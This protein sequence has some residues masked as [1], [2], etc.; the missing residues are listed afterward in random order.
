M[1]RTQARPTSAE[2]ATCAEIAAAEL[3]QLIQESNKIIDSLVLDFKASISAD[4]MNPSGIVYKRVTFDEKA[5]DVEVSRATYHEILRSQ[6]SVSTQSIEALIGGL[7]YLDSIMIKDADFDFDAKNKQNISLDDFVDIVQRLPRV[8]GLRVQWAE[9]LGLAGAFA[10]I[11]PHGSLLDGLKGIREMT[12][13]D[14]DNVCDRFQ[15]M[16]RSIVTEEWKKINFVGGSL[17]GCTNLPN[18]FPDCFLEQGPPAEEASRERLDA[19]IGLPSP[20]VLRAM[21][22]EHQSD[23]WFACRA[24]G[25]AT[26]PRLEFARLLETSEESDPSLELLR[27]A[28]VD[29]NFAVG[30]E[31]GSKILNDSGQ[32]GGA[33]DALQALRL[34]R[35]A[36]ESC[37][38]GRF[39]GEHC[40]EQQ[41]IRAAVTLAAATPSDARILR[42]SCYALAAGT[43]ERLFPCTPTLGGGQFAGEV[44]ARGVDVAIQREDS[45]LAADSTGCVVALVF[46]L[47]CGDA[48][49]TRRG[50]DTSLVQ[51][52]Q[53][54]AVEIPGLA[55]APEVAVRRSACGT[56]IYAETPGEEG[57]RRFLHSLG[58]EELR[59]RAAAIV[60]TAAVLAL[61]P[62]PP[63]AEEDCISTLLAAG[64][65]VVRP[66]RR[67]LS[68]AQLAMLDGVQAARLRLDEA[69]AAHLGTGP[70][71]QVRRG[72]ARRV[73][74][75]PLLD[76]YTQIQQRKNAGSISYVAAPSTWPEALLHNYGH[77][78]LHAET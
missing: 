48:D 77:L 60:S 11:L 62:S 33:E 70:L 65:W 45:G 54:T 24:S 57:L 74:S 13:C 35:A 31:R 32:N 52:V 55:G 30:A 27:A 26:T 16:L 71:L 2:M 58:G 37:R 61:S 69:I 40:D 22:C 8:S 23:K 78:Y 3:K 75:C 10:S 20:N 39:P 51:A 6:G 76:C 19:L 73:R 28:C 50:G 1:T 66:A 46:S 49:Y 17:S 25:L 5:D 53:E 47:P 29:S 56:V 18:Q 44:S 15:P 59:R 36:V 7:T 34:A 38:S 9:S 41:A 14:I 72:W 68:V 21:L 12:A 43:A 42:H 67:R 64:D 63:V 4:K